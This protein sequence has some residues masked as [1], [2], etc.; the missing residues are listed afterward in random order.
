MSNYLFSVKAVKYGTPTGLATL[1]DLT[2][3]PDTVKGSVSIDETEGSVTKFFVDQKKE[4]IKVLKTEEGELTATL[5]FYDM[6][7]ATLAAFKGGHGAGVTGYTPSTGYT[8][9]EKA[10]EIEL[11]SGHK[12]NIFNAQC[13]SRITGG[14]GRDKM[15]ALE[16]KATPQLTADS[17]G[18]W[19]ITP[20]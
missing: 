2:T 11:D 1:P 17:L 5:Q 10:L 4:P 12:V 6:S 19:T 7:Y 8:L 20:V 13:V 18:S 14:G 3:L 9:I 16:I 15:L